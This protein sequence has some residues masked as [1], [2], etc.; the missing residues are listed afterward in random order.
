[1]GILL[2]LKVFTF[3][4][5]AGD[6]AGDRDDI[7]DEFTFNLVISSDDTDDDDD[8]DAER[9]EVSFSSIATTDDR[10]LRRPVIQH[11]KNRLVGHE[12]ITYIPGRGSSAA[13]ARP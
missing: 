13:S 9:D 2:L 12:I 11:Q 5:L 3:S 7:K 1:M 10:R 4:L 6:V 8:D